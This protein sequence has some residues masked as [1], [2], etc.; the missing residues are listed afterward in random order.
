M[1]AVWA[2]V[3]GT[4]CS[5]ES[6]T[7]GLGTTARADPTVSNAASQPPAWVTPTRS[8]ETSWLPGLGEPPLH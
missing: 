7:G 5:W 3:T 6:L 1:P 2:P 8:P 4:L